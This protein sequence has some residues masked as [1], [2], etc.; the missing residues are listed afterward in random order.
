PD[1]S[2]NVS[3][4][5]DL[6]PYAENHGIPSIHF[7]KINKEDAYDFAK[8]QNPDLLF[9]IGLSQ[10]VRE[11]LLSLARY[12]NVGFHPTRLPK[13]RGRGAVA[14]MIL[15]KVKGAATFFLL[16]EGMDSGPILGQKNFD[17]KENDYASDVIEKIKSAISEVLNGM[18]PQLNEGK[19]ELKPQ[20][21]SNATYLGR[22]KPKDGEIDWNRSCNEIYCLIR[23]T[24]HPLPG[25]YSYWKEGK[26]IIHRATPAKAGKYTG[27]PGRILEIEEKNILVACHEGAIWLEEY[28]AE[29]T[30]EFKVGA[31]LG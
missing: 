1:S 30:N 12:G 31:D 20:N 11:P 15:G 25:A 2:K 27:V 24:A 22:R 14:W 8:Q 9:V 3:G 16:D 6:K 7:N 17:V 13:G 19:L 5:Q 18:L 29:S 23:A 21:H 28:S 10:M 26:L 4:Y